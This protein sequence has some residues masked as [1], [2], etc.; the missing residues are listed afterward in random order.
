MAKRRD[1]LETGR[2]RARS[3]SDIPIDS[4]PSIDDLK[5]I[6][7]QKYPGLLEEI[8]GHWRNYELRKEEADHSIKRTTVSSAFLKAHKVVQ[9]LKSDLEQQKHLGLD[10]K[11]VSEIRAAAIP[12]LIDA[13]TSISEFD[14]GREKLV[15]ALDQF[16][17]TLLGIVA[18]L[19]SA[20][21]TA[22]TDTEI[23]EQAQMNVINSLMRRGIDTKPSIRGPLIDIL[24]RLQG[25]ETDSDEDLRRRENL[26]DALTK[27]VKKKMPEI[28]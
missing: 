4:I 20:P 14:D 16:E 25:L 27:L 5:S 2:L 6:D 28:F 17:M 3:G 12:V 13:G 24:M 9:T 22:W 1:E 7:W 15:E 19:E 21:S 26:R 10:Q 11:I 18:A 8:T 23:L